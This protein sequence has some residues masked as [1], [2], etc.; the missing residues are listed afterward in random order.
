[1]LVPCSGVASMRKS[2]DVGDPR[3]SLM[4]GSRNGTK[5]GV[6]RR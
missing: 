5:W 3:E 4:G 2:G 6:I 1:M